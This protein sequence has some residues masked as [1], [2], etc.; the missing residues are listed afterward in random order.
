M[1][2]DGSI[3]H[4]LVNDAAAGRMRKNYKYGKKFCVMLA[5]RFTDAAREW[6]I[7]SGKN[8]GVNCWR[9]ASP[10]NCP[11]DVVEIPFIKVLRQQ[12]QNS[13]S[14]ESALI[15]LKTLKWNFSEEAPSAFRTRVSS[16]FTKAGINEYSARRPFILGVL[17]EDMRRQIMR[18]NTEVDLWLKI[19]EAVA[20]E[21]SIKATRNKKKSKDSSEGKKDKRDMKDLTCYTCQKKGHISP[22]CP[23]NKDGKKEKEKG[24][25]KEK[26]EKDDKDT[27]YN[28]EGRGHRSPECPSRSYSKGKDKDKKSTDKV[29][30]SLH[31]NT[32]EQSPQFYYHSQPSSSSQYK[33]SGASDDALGSYYYPMN[34]EDPTKAFTEFYSFDSLPWYEENEESDY[35]WHQEEAELYSLSQYHYDIAKYGPSDKMRNDEPGEFYV[36]EMESNEQPPIPTCLVEHSSLSPITFGDMFDALGQVMSSPVVPPPRGSMRTYAYT[37]D[38]KRMLTVGDTGTAVNVIPKSVLEQTGNKVTRP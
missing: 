13:R 36:H 14:Q 33:P 17:D 19:E 16:L 37:M 9:P 23:E 21:E 7:T 29:S 20:T 26:S 25:K 35:H 32:R 10:G 8:S 5:E 27:C 22:N 30:A 11:A 38:N 15:A 2:M 1:R 31:L 6:W 24:K 34:T 12:F 18:P 3:V 28:C 4:P